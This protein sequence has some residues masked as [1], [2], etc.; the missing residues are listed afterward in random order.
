MSLE[1][2]NEKGRKRQVRKLYR[3]MKAW[4]LH[5][6]D[7]IRYEEIERPQPADCEVLVRVQAA[8]ICGSDVPRIYK[9]GAHVHPLIPGHEFSG[10]VEKTG[11]STNPEW[12]GKRVGVFPL[13]PCRECIPCRKRQYELCRNY[14][15]LGSRRN[16]G[17]AEYVL[18]P[19]WNLIELPANVSFTEAAMLEPMAVA[20]HAMRRVR[21]SHGEWAV[22]YGLG[23]IGMSLVMFLMEAGVHNIMAVGNKG[24]QLQIACRLGLDGQRCCDSRGQDAVQWVREH[25][26][27]TG[28]DIVFECVGRNETIAQAVRMAAPSGY[29][30]LVGNPYSDMMLDKDIYWKILRDQLVIT[31]TWNSSF[32]HHPD[33]DWHYVLDRFSR[34]RVSPENLVTHRLPVERLRQGLHIM[35]DKTEDYIKIM[36]I[37]TGRPEAEEAHCT[38]VYIQGDQ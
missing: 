7:D 2:F 33:D 24:F 5:G 29:V 19:E 10:I 9:T 13:I 20:V 30:C 38:G 28:A 15:Y 17:F 32:M 18:V 11:T 14:S 21:I 23:T 36:A 26:D 8:G 25:T 35:R 1:G 34:K 22:V 31:G 12:E 4:V 16:G 27:G 37:G 3:Q 6:A